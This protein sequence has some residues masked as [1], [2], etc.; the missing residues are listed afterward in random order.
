MYCNT[1]NFA[2][3]IELLF[4]AEDDQNLR[5][6]L[7][8]L[9]YFLRRDQDLEH[10]DFF[11]EALVSKSGEIDLLL[12]DKLC[13][14]DFY[15][16]ELYDNFYEKVFEKIISVY[17]ELDSTSGTLK[18][19][20]RSGSTVIKFESL[21][22]LF[23]KIGITN[24]KKVLALW[25]NGQAPSHFIKAALI[26]SLSDNSFIDSLKTE[27]SGV[28]IDKDFDSL[29]QNILC[30]SPEHLSGNTKIVS[31]EMSEIDEIMTNL[32]SFCPTDKAYGLHRLRQVPRSGFDLSCKL[33]EAVMSCLFDDDR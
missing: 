26:A 21:C 24:I 19:T 5:T 14:W 27:A 3:I 16:D 22:S 31:S 28:D 8:K 33:L 20:I 15:I 18:R 2:D 6:L 13:S 11:F 29:P 10:F 25:E 1:R 17:L 32:K 4:N 7:S 12:F 30:K 23:E 9:F